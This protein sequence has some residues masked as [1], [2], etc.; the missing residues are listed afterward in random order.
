MLE[1]IKAFQKFK[2]L[3]FNTKTIVYTENKNIISPGCLT[4]RMNRWKLMLQEF[5]HEIKHIDGNRNV[6][7]DM[8][9]RTCIFKISD[10]KENYC[11]QML[12]N[13]PPSIMKTQT[14]K[15]KEA[16]ISKEEIIK[17]LEDIHKRL[18]HPDDTKVFMTLK[19]YI[20]IPK[21]RQLCRQIYSNCKK[22][23]TEKKYKVPNISPNYKFNIKGVND[24]V[25]IDINGPIPHKYFKNNKKDSNFFILVMTDIFSRFSMISILTNIYSTTVAN[26]FE[27]KWIKRFNAPNYCL[28]DNGRQFTSDNFNDLLKRYNIKHSYSSPYN[29]K[30]NSVVKSFNREVGTVLRLSRNETLKKLEKNLFIRLNMT[31]NRIT[32]ETLMKHFF[33]KPIFSHY[34]CVMRIE[35]DVLLQKLKT[36]HDLLI[37]K[38]NKN[39]KNSLKIGQLVYLKNFEQYKMLPIYS[40]PYMI[41]EI[42]KSRSHLFLNKNKKIVR[43]SVKH[44]SPV[45]ER[46]M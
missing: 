15:S 38:I 42:S 23:L 17:F 29:P 16:P 10:F 31:T 30:G 1:I 5:D 43:A 27:E 26:E 14:P 28:T 44:I 22:C 4:R 7:A 33:K 40:G 34:S 35:N 12:L 45:R 37:K 19:K 36:R 24:V 3:L 8:L 6:E 32:N 9:S 18:I 25:S 20:E 39:R 46:E 21:L 13:A 11:N 41:T 2:Y